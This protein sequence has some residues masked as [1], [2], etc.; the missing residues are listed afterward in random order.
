MPDRLRLAET[1]TT[2]ASTAD[3]DSGRLWACAVSRPSPDHPIFGRH[4]VRL[5]GVR[6]PCAPS[7]FVG[8]RY[9][10]DVGGHHPGPVHVQTLLG[11]S[12]RWVLIAAR[13]RPGSTA[14]CPT[15]E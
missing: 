14:A 11:C 7:A 13:E 8:G 5:T 12:V 1:R 3:R 9:E 2:P 6:T 15:H 10:G 4:A